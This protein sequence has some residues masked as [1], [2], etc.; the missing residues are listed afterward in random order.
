MKC[1]A[2]TV[3]WLGVV[4]FFT[5]LSSEMIYPLMPIFL[6]KVLGAGVVSIGV[7]EGIAEATASLLKIVSGF[8]T[9]Y[10]KRRKPFILLGYGISGLFRP[11]I[12][13]ALSWTSV[14]FFR[15]LDR[16][17]KG[18][19]SSPR[20]TLIADVTPP[21]LR[22]SAYGLHRAMDHAGAVAGPLVA[23]LLLSVFML[24]LRTV[25]YLS[26]VP[27][28]IAFLCIV[29]GVQEDKV[30]T[31]AT[32][33]SQKISFA[34]LVLTWKQM[35]VDLKIIFLAVFVFSLGNAT[36]AFLLL[37][38]NNSGVPTAM[39]AI[40]WSVHH[41]IKMVSVYYGGKLSDQWGHKKMLLTGWVFYAT[42]YFVFA[43]S[44][45]YVTS[46]LVFLIYGIF[47]GFVEPAER[48]LVSNLAKQHRRGSVF[49]FFHFFVGL[50]AL[51]ASLLFGWLWMRWGYPVAFMV[52]AMLALVA[53][54]ILLQSNHQNKV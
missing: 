21:Q 15:F 51:P 32:D 22:G 14:V 4:S 6:V 16:I 49:G 12:G 40:L 17:G 26:I 9:D 18:I 53:A 20:D 45:S 27:G 35:A 43:G 23:A 5:D 41:V 24:E 33:T 8:W 52:G 39:V 1:L 2:K 13:T 29:W 46:I 10:L 28:I 38:L 30:V 7:V 42:I 19:R 50:G 25:I 36:D 44:L 47:Y 34:L 11:L 37:R 54:L 31:V 48:A 3:V